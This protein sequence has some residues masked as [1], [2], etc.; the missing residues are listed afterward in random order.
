MIG[1][2]AENHFRRPSRTVTGDKTAS[3]PHVEEGDVGVCLGGR[4]RAADQ[5]LSCGEGDEETIISWLFGTLWG[6]T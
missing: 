5:T 1:A 4:G 3:S 2:V 6:V